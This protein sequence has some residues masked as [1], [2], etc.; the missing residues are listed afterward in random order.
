MAKYGAVLTKLNKDLKYDDI[1]RKD[2][3]H[4]NLLLRDTIR[5]QE[6]RISTL[7]KVLTEVV[8]YYNVQS[9]GLQEKVKGAMKI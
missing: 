3:L 8:Y 7:K 6:E 1:G 4:E 5:A 9:P 2:V